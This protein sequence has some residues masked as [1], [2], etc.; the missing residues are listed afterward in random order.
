MERFIMAGALIPYELTHELGWPAVRGLLTSMFL[1]G[2]WLHLIGN[3]LYLWIFGDNIEEQFGRLGYVI[4]YLVGGVAAGLA[5]VAI[6]PGSTVP[7][8]GASGAVAA[9]L[10]AYLVLYPRAR[11]RTL[12]LLFYFIRLV[13]LPAVLVLGLWFVMQ[14][15]SGVSSL[16]NVGADGVAYF[17]HIGGFLLGMLAGFLARGRVREAALWDRP[18]G[19]PGY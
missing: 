13:D 5:Q 9:I 1:H 18:P 14:L 10:G 11:V 2:G 7:T 17:A 4:L 6:D 19:G 12:V 8:I 3:M 15:F 16:A